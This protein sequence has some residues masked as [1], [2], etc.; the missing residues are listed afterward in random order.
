M[1]P[2]SGQGGRSGVDPVAHY[3]SEHRT[4]SMALAMAAAG[5]GEATA[6]EPDRMGPGWGP[7]AHVPPEYQ[8]K[9]Q[10]SAILPLLCW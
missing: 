5:G 8:D 3:E 2:S 1:A 9:E 6:V 7:R 4:E 10:V